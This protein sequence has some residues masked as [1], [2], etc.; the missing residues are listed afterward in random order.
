[1]FGKSQRLRVSDS[2]IPGVGSYDVTANNIRRSRGGYSLGKSKRFS[3][4]NVKDYFVWFGV[5]SEIE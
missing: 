5:L 4:G 1:M 3:L 2:K